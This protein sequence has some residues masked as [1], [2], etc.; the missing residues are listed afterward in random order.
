[1]TKRDIVTLTLGIIGGIFFAMT[2]LLIYLA[3]F[4][5]QNTMLFAVIDA[6][7]TLIFGIING[8]HRSKTKYL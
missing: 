2:L 5:H 6:V 7:L 1:M 8:I 3:L 4:R